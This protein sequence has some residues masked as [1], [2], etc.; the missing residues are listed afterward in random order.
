MTLSL[1]NPGP[2]PA[3]NDDVFDRLNRKFPGV[4]PSKALDGPDS[5]CKTCN[6]KRVFRWLRDLDSAIVPVRREVPRLDDPREVDVTY[7]LQVPELA[8]YECECWRQAR[9]QAYL[10]AHGVGLAGARA[11]WADA[12]WVPAHLHGSLR[13]YSDNCADWA[14]RGMGLYLYSPLYGGG[15]SLV[16]TMVLKSFLAAGVEGHWITF[17]DMLAMHTS[18]WRDKEEREWFE[19]RVRNAQVLVID[20]VGKESNFQPTDADG[21]KLPTNW[22]S[23]VTSALDMVF[24]TRVQNGMVTI[25]TSNLRPEEIS[26]SYTPALGS[27]ATE[28]CLPY[29]FPSVDIRVLA[30]ERTVAEIKHGLSRPFTFG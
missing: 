15:K 12:T 3:L 26:S 7:E 6:G 23:I 13:E 29:E 20:D 24:R 8:D 1:P 4:L 11:R 16:A 27:L 2:V 5:D 17:Q 30:R 22:K 18:S 21:R 14:S 25:I 10:L 28:A 9:I 19:T